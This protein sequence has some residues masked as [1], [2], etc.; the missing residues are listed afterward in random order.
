MLLIAN[1]TI[2]TGGLGFVTSSP[3][4]ADSPRLVADSEV[5]DPVTAEETTAEDASA[6]AASAEADQTGE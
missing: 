2:L 5:P 4:Q 1:G 6:P 3:D